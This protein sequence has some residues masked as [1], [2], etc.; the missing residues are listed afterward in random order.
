MKAIGVLEVASNIAS[1][2]AVDDMVKAA[3]V[4]LVTTEKALGGRLVSIVIEG[5][6]AD[7]KEAIACGVRSAERVGK[8]AAVAIMNSPH[9]EVSKLLLHSRRK[10]NV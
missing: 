5:S 2:V 8:V 1:I 7:V 6:V 4:T 3:D 9:E 10:L